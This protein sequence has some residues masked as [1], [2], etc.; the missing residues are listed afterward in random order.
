MPAND[1]LLSTIR[2]SVSSR[3]L[4]IAE[5][6][7]A[8][9]KRSSLRRYEAVIALARRRARDSV[10]AST[11]VVANSSNETAMPESNSQSSLARFG[12][13]VATGPE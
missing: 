7:I 12:A 4:P 10:D 2:P 6:C 5:Y 1:G 11:H 9:R 3:A 8:L 13:A